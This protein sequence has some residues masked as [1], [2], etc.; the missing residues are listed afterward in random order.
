MKKLT[1]ILVALLLLMS[2]A[3]CGASDKASDK[4]AEKTAEKVIEDALGDDVQVDIEGDK[5]TYKDKDGNKLE[6]GGTEWPSD[7]AASFIPKFDKGTITASSIVDNV[8]LIDVE[9]VEKVDYDRYLQTVKDAGFTESSFSF[10]E[11]DYYQ[12]QALHT[13]GTS[14]ILTYEAA[15]KR[16]QITGT[17]AE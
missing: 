8:Y 11:A 12:Y 16:L 15:E 5:Y 9:K 13:D 6:V 7:K 1:I 17:A 2:L 10:E 4:A 14:I 3:G